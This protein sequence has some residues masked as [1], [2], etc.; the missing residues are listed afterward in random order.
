M[1]TQSNDVQIQYHY[2]IEEPELKTQQWTLRDESRTVKFSGVKLASVSSGRDNR[3]RW[4]VID[5]YRTAGGVFIGHRVGKS[6]IVHDVGCDNIP[7]KRLP[8]I[9]KCETS[10][11]DRVPCHICKPNIQKA[12]QTDPASL[13]I[14]VDRYW[15]SVTESAEQLFNDL[16]T[17]RHGDRTLSYLATTLLTKA[18]EH[19]AQISAVVEKHGLS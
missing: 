3:P 8:G 11:E 13:R 4:T 2:D 17:I 14:E 16:H 15:T 1:T 9:E 6:L 5:I 12:L 19:D 10:I 7:G 18:A